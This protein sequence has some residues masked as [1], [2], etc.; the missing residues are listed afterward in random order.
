[1][2]TTFLSIAL[3]MSTAAVAQ[4]GDMSAP[5]GADMSAPVEETTMPDAM[6]DTTTSSDWSASPNDQDVA[7]DMTTPEAPMAQP[8][9][10][11]DAAASAPMP[12]TTLASVVEPS[13]ADPEHDARGIKVISASAD[14]PAG[15]NGMTGSA[16][17][18]PLVDPATGAAVEASADSY[19]ACSATVTDNCLQEYE[20]G[21]EG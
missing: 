2:R 19:P 7:T 16:Q 5:A 17:G 4:T 11:T 14:V 1:M 15:F 20:R 10:M 21:R 6:S 18:G 13:N 12:A 9:P 3:L 8:D